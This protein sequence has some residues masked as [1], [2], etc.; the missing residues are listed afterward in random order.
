LVQD[1]SRVEVRWEGT[2]SGLAPELRG[3]KVG[4]IASEDA[5][6]QLIDILSHEELFVAAHVM[7]TQVSGIKYE[8][9]PTWNGLA[10]EIA[11]NGIAT[12]NP[13]E[14]FALVRRWKKWYQSQPHPNCLP[15][16]TE[17][18]GPGRA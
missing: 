16:A 8:T 3:Y 18:E 4:S 9:F 17:D 2:D 13:N 7:L 6:S 10:V 11:A 5:I 12:I 15:M 1:L 14:R